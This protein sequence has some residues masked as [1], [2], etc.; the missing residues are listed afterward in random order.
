[1]STLYQLYVIEA[2]RGT[3]LAGGC[4]LV[5]ILRNLIKRVETLEMM[6]HKYA[7]YWIRA[8]QG[9]HPHTVPV[10]YDEATDDQ[11]NTAADTTLRSPR[12]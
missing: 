9:G 11:I 6:H 8:E 1:M 10:H 3:I 4:V 2:I 5:I 7:M 12:T